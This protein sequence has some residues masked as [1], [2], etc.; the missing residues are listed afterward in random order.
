MVV[1]RAKGLNTGVMEVVVVVITRVRIVNIV[2]LIPFVLVEV[3]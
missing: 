1:V 2:H 3:A